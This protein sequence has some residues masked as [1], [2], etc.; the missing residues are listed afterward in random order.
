MDDHHQEVIA[1]C[2]E[3]NFSGIAADDA[4]Y[5]AFDPPRYFSSEQ[6]KLTYKVIFS[7]ENFEEFKCRK[8]VYQ[9][10][11]VSGLPGNERIHYFRSHE[12][13]EYSIGQALHPG[14]PSWKLHF[15]RARLGRILQEIEYHDKLG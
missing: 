4:D 10:I 3:N 6:L 13:S 11:F 15:A 12:D 8:R 14:G 1:Y 5:A 2:R 9:C 7:P